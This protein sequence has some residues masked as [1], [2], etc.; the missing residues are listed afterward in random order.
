[1]VE[2]PWM[3]Y[4]WTMHLRCFLGRHR[5]MLTSIIKRGEG[6]AALCDDCAAPIEREQSGRWTHSQ[7]LISKRDQAA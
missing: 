3:T 7:P 2:A 1:M 6:F 5:P 4:P